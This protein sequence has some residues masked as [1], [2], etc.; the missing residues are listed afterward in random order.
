MLT[1]DQLVRWYSIT[2]ELEMLALRLNSAARNVE[3][4]RHRQQEAGIGINQIME[5]EIGTKQ[6]SQELKNL[7]LRM[8]QDVHPSNNRI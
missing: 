4:V 7:A 1:Q 6:V 3:M 5:A 8:K 2:A